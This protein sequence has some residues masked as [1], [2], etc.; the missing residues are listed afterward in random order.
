MQR[1]ERDLVVDLIQHFSVGIQPPGTLDWSWTKAEEEE[2]KI[3]PT[4]VRREV[5]ERETSLAR[6]R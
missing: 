5:G 6:Q 1:D 2:A 4:L 3:L